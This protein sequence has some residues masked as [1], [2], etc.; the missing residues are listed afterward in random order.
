MVRAA[1]T[2]A[3]CFIAGAPPS[4]RVRQAEAV[5]RIAHVRVIEIAGGGT[6]GGGVVL[7]RAPFENPLAAIRRLPGRAVARRAAVGAMPAIR[8]P[9]VDPARHV[10]QPE[11]VGPEAADFQRLLGVVG[12]AAALA[13]RETKQ[14]LVAPI[15]LRARAGP[16]GVLP[17]GLAR[18]AVTLL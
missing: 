7:P 18:Q 11:G 9:L 2:S 4:V 16:R 13:V 15:I 14:E 1:N 6:H 17:L 5:R 8:D 10:V 12:L 3:L